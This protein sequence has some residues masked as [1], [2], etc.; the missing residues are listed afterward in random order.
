MR[1]WL[2]L[3]LGG[4]LAGVLAASGQAQAV[5]PFH[6]GFFPSGPL[7][8]ITD[9]AGV[10]VANLTL[11]Q[12]SDIRTGATAVLPNADPWVHKTAAASLAFNGNGEM[13]GTHWIDE[14]GYLEEP[15]VLT[16]TLDVGLAD[17]GVVDWMIAHHP[18]VGV[19]DDVPLPVVAECD[20]QLLND[21]QKRVVRPSDVH[22]L[23]DAAQPGQ[24]ARGSVGAGTGMK[25]FG[26][27]AG[28]GTASRVLPASLGGYTVGVLVNDNTGSSRQALTIVGVPVG[29]KLKDEYRPKYPQH[30]SEADLHGRMLSGS[31]IIVVATNAPLDSRQLHAILLRAALG[32]GRTGLTSDIGSGDLFVAFSTSVVFEQTADFDIAA[33]KQQFTENDRVLNAL[34]SAT[35]EA[36]QAAIYDALFEAKTMTG[37]GGTTMYGLPVDRVLQMLRSAGAVSQ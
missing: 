26:F 23:L 32:M 1:K 2:P 16:D 28:I 4:C 36:T 11:I 19:T 27:K 24:F 13:T 14:S 25:A 18:A 33:P 31:I 3:V 22:K 15:V 12:G 8:A 34:Y 6:F 20:D 17:D 30:L 37:R 35:A 10:R 21:I 29:E 5:L 9:V 7:D